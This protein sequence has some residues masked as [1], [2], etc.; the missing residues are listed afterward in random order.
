MKYLGSVQISLVTSYFYF[1]CSICI[2]IPIRSTHCNWRT[3][4]LIKSFLVS[5]SF[6]S[7]FFLLRVLL[8]EDQAEC[9]VS[10][11]SLHFLDCVTVVSLALPL[12]PLFAV[13]WQLK[14]ILYQ[15]PSSQLNCVLVVGK[16]CTLVSHVHLHWT[17]AFCV[18]S[19]CF[20]LLELPLARLWATRID[21]F[22]LLYFHLLFFLLPGKNPRLSLSYS[23]EFIC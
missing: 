6:L 8:L 17:G 1:F 15:Y 16:V 10:F 7:I 3:G 23:L 2:R 19:V 5:V 21:S 14:G 12:F 20:F 22:S 18:P 11:L 4:L 9:L 13:D